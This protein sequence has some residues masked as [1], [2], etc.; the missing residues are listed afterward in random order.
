[1]ELKELHEKKVKDILDSKQILNLPLLEKK[2]SIEEVFTVLTARDHVW[3][4]AEKGSK[5]L[6]GIITESD[7]LRSIVP[8]RL[9]KYVFG[10]RHGISYQHGTAKTAEDIMHKR[11]H[12]CSPDDNL[13]EVLSRMVNANFRR[14]PVVE[15]DEL[16]GEIT[17]H[18]ILQI[19]LGKR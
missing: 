7:V 12:T 5:Q 9:P 13:G 3:I 11:L 10:T 4:V 18:H 15:K 14:L 6:A 8:P 1:M 19:L 2:K 16:V 17:I